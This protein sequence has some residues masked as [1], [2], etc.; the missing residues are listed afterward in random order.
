[1]G[2]SV[3]V[4]YTLICKLTRDGQCRSLSDCVRAG[5]SSKGGWRGADSNIGG[6][7]GSGPNWRRHSIVT[8]R[9]SHGSGDWD[10]VS[11]RAVC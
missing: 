10:R 7:G 5:A 2:T 8:G 6:D 4:H 9:G 1:L 3:N 11:A